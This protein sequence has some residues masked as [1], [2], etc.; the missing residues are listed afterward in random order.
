MM[1][2]AWPAAAIGLLQ[3]GVA[4]RGI[5]IE[6]SESVAAAFG[7]F[8]DIER[9]DQLRSQ[10]RIGSGEMQVRMHV[11]ALARH[12]R[13]RPCDAT[14]FSCRFSSPPNFHS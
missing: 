4:L 5:Q 12:R 10:L 13:A 7:H 2:N 1:V 3:L 14:S 6:R 11:D 9:R 8:L